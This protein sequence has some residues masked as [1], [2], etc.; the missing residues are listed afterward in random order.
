MA[1]ATQEAG[2]QVFNQLL[3]SRTL[4][5]I[6]LIA[7]QETRNGTFKHTMAGQPIRQVATNTDPNGEQRRCALPHQINRVGMDLGKCG[8]NLL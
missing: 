1:V 2:A 7:D 5:A 4:V 8:R 3:R 6:R